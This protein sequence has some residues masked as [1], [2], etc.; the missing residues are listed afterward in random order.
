MFSGKGG[1][2]PIMRNGTV[3]IY[4]YSNDDEE[5]IL[6]NEYIVYNK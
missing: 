5:C 6:T 1:V 2:Y 3:K 4:V